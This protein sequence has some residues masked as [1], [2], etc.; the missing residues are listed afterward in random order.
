VKARQPQAVLVTGASRGIGRAC[1]VSFA[2]HGARVAINHPGESKAA[3]DTA[4]LVREAGG[5]PLVVRADV[6]ARTE[7][8][9]MVDEVLEAFGRVDVA[10]LNAGICP[11]TPFLEVSEEEWD[12][13]QAV[14]AK[15]PFLVSQALAPAMIEAGS[16]RL[17]AIGSISALTGGA[18]QAPYCASK[19]AL[20]SLM[21]SLAIALGPHGITCN[22]VHPGPVETDI[23]RE[24]LATGG[25]REEFERRIP[26]GRI[27]EPRDVADV[28]RL[29]AAEGTR[30]VNG[31]EL[32]VDGGLLVHLQ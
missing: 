14:N 18:H 26:S 25:K 24:D 27:G 17:I 15:G 6:A 16:G 10:V 32:V 20:S 11:F 28:V 21:R 23:N 1:A 12:R 19:A 8:H 31:A 4:R 22:V 2:E 29:L 13:V 9:E 30:W 5:E 7:V 3:A